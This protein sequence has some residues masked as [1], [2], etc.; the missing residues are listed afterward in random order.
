[1][2][3]SGIIWFFLSQ[4]LQQIEQFS[5]QIFLIPTETY[6]QIPTFCL[7]IYSNSG[8]QACDFKLILQCRNTNHHH[9]DF[10]LFRCYYLKTDFPTLKKKGYFRSLQFIIIKKTKQNT[11][12]PTD[13][14]PQNPTQMLHSDTY[15][16]PHHHPPHKRNYSLSSLVKRPEKI[17]EGQGHCL[18]LPCLSSYRGIH[19]QPLLQAQ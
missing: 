6:H 2:S 17:L 3:Y 1:M 13:S 14:K 18:C 11:P 16:F 19:S 15:L 8:P 12:M 9:L 10:V 4:L 7:K 5:L